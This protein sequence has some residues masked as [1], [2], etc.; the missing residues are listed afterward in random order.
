MPLFSA[1]DIADFAAMK[2]DLAYADAY[3]VEREVETSRDSRNNPVMEWQT[4]EA[5]TGRLRATNRQS[6]ERII[7]DALG[8]TVAYAIDVPYDTI[9]ANDDR[10]T[11]QDREF[12][13]GSVIREGNF[14]IDATI[15]CEE[16]SH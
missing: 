14:G 12:R 8:W 7:A 5:G 2:D 6:Q 1:A 3:R 9:A 4:V 15:I 13:I 16:R 10:L 11:I